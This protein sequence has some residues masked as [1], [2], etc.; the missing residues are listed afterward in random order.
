MS[1]GGHFGLGSCHFQECCEL[2]CNWEPTAE[3]SS[4]RGRHY[5]HSSVHTTLFEIDLSSQSKYSLS[6]EIEY[7][8]ILDPSEEKFSECD[9]QHADLPC[10]IGAYSRTRISGD[11]KVKGTNCLNTS[12]DKILIYFGY[13]ITRHKADIGRC[14]IG[15]RPMEVGPRAAT[16]R[17]EVRHM[18]QEKAE[19][20]NQEVRNLL[21]FGMIQSSLSP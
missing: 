4:F 16:H 11:T 1:Q 8:F 17:E 14:K 3:D 15:K 13:L 21:P 18:L 5:N 20:I 2:L 19:R 12:L 6:S 10:S 9:N 7:I